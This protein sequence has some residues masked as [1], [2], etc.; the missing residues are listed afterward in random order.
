MQSL[1]EDDSDMTRQIVS[2]ILS[3][4]FGLLSCSVGSYLICTHLHEPIVFFGFVAVMLGVGH[5]ISVRVH[6][7]T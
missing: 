3:G 5:L 1:P 4:V 2:R 6:E 7:H